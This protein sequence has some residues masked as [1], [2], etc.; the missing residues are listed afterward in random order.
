MGQVIQTIAVASA[1]CVLVVGLWQG[2]GTLAVLK[3]AVIAYLGFFAL[4]AGLLL[5]VRSGALK[6][7]EPGEP[8]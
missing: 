5:L 4:G 2:W 6:P 3:R 8:S 1:A 7:R